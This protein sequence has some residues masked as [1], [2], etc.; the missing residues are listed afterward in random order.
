[1]PPR[2]RIPEGGHQMLGFAITCFALM[3][4]WSRCLRITPQMLAEQVRAAN[5]GDPQRRERI[6]RG[7]SLVAQLRW[8]MPS[9]VGASM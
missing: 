7:M 5:P 6:L 1:M 8:R 9:I 2:T 4:R 3:W